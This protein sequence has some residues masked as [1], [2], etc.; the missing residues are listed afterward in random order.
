MEKELKNNKK[1][2][3]IGKNISYSFSKGYFTEKF[4][5]LNLSNHYYENFDLEVITELNAIIAENN[6]AGLN[7]TIPYK[8]EII[9]YLDDIDEIA[10]EIGAVNT[11]KVTKTGIKGY[12]TDIYGFKQAITKHLKS[13]HKK[14]LILGTGGASKAVAY[15][16]YQLGILYKFVSRKPVNDQLS[17]STLDKEKIQAYQIIVNCSPVGTYPNINK[18]PNIPYEGLGKNHL[19][20]DLIYNPNKT[21]FLKMGEAAGSVI[22]NGL[23]MLEFQAEK[24]WNIWNS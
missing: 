16:F 12:N 24:A 11:I 15:V 10:K 1:Y 4:K 3:L 13:N 9:P 8:E 23:S 19:L 6:L 14:A 21:A 17:Y 5:N 2:G 20:F 22:E 18:K 7:V